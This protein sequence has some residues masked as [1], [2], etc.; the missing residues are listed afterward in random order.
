MQLTHI[1]GWCISW[2]HKDDPTDSDCNK[3]QCY[4]DAV[5]SMMRNMELSITVKGHGCE[6]H[7]VEQMRYLAKYGGM[8]EY[9]ESWVELYHQIGYRFDVRLRNMGS[10]DGKAHT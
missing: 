3:A 9:D 8:V 2:L 10:E 4:I 5:V 7:I 1:M 6:D